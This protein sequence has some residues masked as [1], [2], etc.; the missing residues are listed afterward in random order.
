[1]KASRCQSLDLSKQGVSQ[2]LARKEGRAGIQTPESGS[3]RTGREPG[4]QDPDS[5][6]WICPK[7]LRLDLSEKGVS[8]EPKKGEGVKGSRLQSL[9]LPDEGVSQEPKIRNGVGGSRLQSLDL[10]EEG[11]SQEP[12][13]GEG[14]G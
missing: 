13:R 11:V 3:V 10:S 8:Q 9:D 2:E 5:R 1:M 6:V 14:K 12:K 4:A 7:L